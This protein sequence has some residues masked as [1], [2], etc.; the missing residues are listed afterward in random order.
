MPHRMCIILF[1][2]VCFHHYSQCLSLST[3][4]SLSELKQLQRKIIRTVSPLKMSTQISSPE[5]TSEFEYITLEYRNK[6]FKQ[7]SRLGSTVE[8]SPALVLNADYSPLSFMPLSLW[9][10]QDTLRAVFSGRAVIIS[11]Y[12]NLYVRSVSE[13]FPIPSV[14]ALKQYHKMPNDK[15]PQLSRRNVYLRDGFRCQYCMEKFAV[16][17]LSLDHVVPRSKGGK[18]TW[19]NTVTSCCACNFKKATTMPEDLPSIGMRL[20]SSPREPSYHELQSKS[21]QF[22]KVQIHPDW[23][24]YI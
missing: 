17:K 1:L 16:D 15:A 5:M 6:E 2:I 12:S 9:G 23:S 8:N 14:I 13:V 10:W 21:K 3:L 20:R 19:L 4:Q 22:K 18:L 7:H 24:D 11:T